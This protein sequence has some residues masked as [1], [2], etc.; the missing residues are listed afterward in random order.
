MPKLE[1]CPTCGSTGID[2][3]PGGINEYDSRKG[4]LKNHLTPDSKPC[5][6]TT[7]ATDALRLIDQWQ[8]QDTIPM[9]N[10]FPKLRRQI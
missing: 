5:I 9:I 7:T 10:P 4:T 6:Q 1:Y 2:V 8:Q 3:I